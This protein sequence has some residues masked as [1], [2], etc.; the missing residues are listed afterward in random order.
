MIKTIL[1]IILVIISILLL[2]VYCSLVLSARVD[3]NITNKN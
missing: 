2:F 3:N 1:L